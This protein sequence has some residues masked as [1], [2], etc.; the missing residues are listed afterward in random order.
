MTA[1]AL[2]PG[3]LYVVQFRGQTWEVWTDHPVTAL[4]SV[5]STIV[6]TVH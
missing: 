1:V 4:L 5:A 6:L 2:I 3:V